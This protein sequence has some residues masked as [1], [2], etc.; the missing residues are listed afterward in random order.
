MVGITWSEVML[1]LCSITAYQVWDVL[2]RF[3]GESIHALHATIKTK[4]WKTWIWE[5]RESILKSPKADWWA[6]CMEK[7]DENKVEIPDDASDEVCFDLVLK[8]V[9]EL[10]QPYLSDNG[11]VASEDDLPVV[12]VA[13]LKSFMMWSHREHVINPE[14]MHALIGLVYI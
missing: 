9:S 4:H 6:Y 10:I 1:F 13:E 3:I 5:T 2:N 14:C 11:F 8:A 7:L 12:D